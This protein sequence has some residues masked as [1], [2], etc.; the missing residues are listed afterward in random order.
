MQIM[1]VEYKK[2]GRK[3][4]GGAHDKN[5]DTKQGKS[6]FFWVMKSWCTQQEQTGALEL[7]GLWEKC[8]DRREEWNNTGKREVVK[9]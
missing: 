2:E 9:V 7:G 3:E 6:T 8:S 1:M 4:E 5:R